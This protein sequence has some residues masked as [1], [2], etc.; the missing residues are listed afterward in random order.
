MSLDPRNHG[1][2]VCGL[3]ADPETANNGNI[4]K[5]RVAADYAGNERNSDNKSGYF[6]V[7]Y[8]L[9]NDNP[10]A[11]FVRK[12]FEDGKLK[13]GSQVIVLYRLVQDRWEKDG[14]KMSSVNLV[15]EALT[16]AGSA[17]REASASGGGGSSDA[18]NAGGGEVPTEF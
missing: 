8:F 15:A 5:L 1:S 17:P 2:L 6:N 11:K 3:V 12:Q 13:K 9:N 16:Y 10:N 4:L 18:G 14:Q 7:T